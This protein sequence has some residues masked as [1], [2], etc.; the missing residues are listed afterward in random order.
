MATSIRPFQKSDVALRG[1][2]P[3]EGEG[4]MSIL[5]YLIVILAMLA[6]ACLLSAIFWPRFGL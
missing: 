4:R 2:G 3:M 1:S 5:E 6:G